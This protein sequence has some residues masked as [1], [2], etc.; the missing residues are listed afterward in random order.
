MSARQ[1]HKCLNFYRK[2]TVIKYQQ[3]GVLKAAW[4]KLETKLK[5]RLKV[6][7]KA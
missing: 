5:T 2:A 1:I 3:L 6:L 7:K 4:I